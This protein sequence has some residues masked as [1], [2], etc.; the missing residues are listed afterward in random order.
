MRRLFAV[1][2]VPAAVL[3]LAAPAS[4]ARPAAA[5]SGSCVVGAGSV[6][7]TGLPTGELIN[8]MVKTDAG[9]SGWVLGFTELGTWTVSV[10]A[11]SVP[12]T[13]EFVSRTWG[14]NGSRYTV[15]ASCA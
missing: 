12:T 13:Y 6:T 4:A 7:A 5:P 11:T 14:P 8:F 3:G 10:P 9:T 2:A 1:L 15:F